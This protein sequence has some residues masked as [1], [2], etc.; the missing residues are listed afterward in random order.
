[1]SRSEPVH[2][3]LCTD[4]VF[5]HA[6]GGMQRH[7]RLLAEHLARGGRVRLTVIHPHEVEVFDPELGIDEVRITDIDPQRFYLRE[8]WRYSG[9]VADALRQQRPDVIL[10]QGFCVWKDIDEFRDRLV[11]HPHGL[12]MFQ[13]LGRK[14]RL[15]GIPFRMAL[16]YILRRSRTVVSLGG[17]LTDILVDQVKGSGASVE[18]LPNAVDP[19]STGIIERPDRRPLQLLFVGRFA[20]NKGIDVLLAVADRLVG[21]GHANDLRFKLV[22]D[23]PL[24]A[25]VQR[26]GLPENV[27]LLGRV[28]DAGLD[29]LYR[30]C[31]AF[32]LPTRFEGMPTVVLEA[33]ARSCPIIVSDVG[34]TAELVDSSNGYLIPPGN[35]DELHRAVLSLEYLT[36]QERALLGERGRNKVGERFT[37]Q[38]VTRAFEDLFIR[39]A[40]EGSN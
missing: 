31:D 35:A 4:G 34:A 24:L 18:V 16:R 38:A 8:L 39:M 6:M 29:R 37:W 40:G 3:V 33:M 32:V 10:A 30:E 13:M 19:I 28:D 27:E 21:E 22:G 1:M 20:F 9:R 25:Q 14:E 15:M 17:R 7:S 23:G 2:V 12:E 36:P 26:K 11:V 5:P